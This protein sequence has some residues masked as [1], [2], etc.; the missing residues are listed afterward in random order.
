M[1]DPTPIVLLYE[2]KKEL[3][4][5]KLLAWCILMVLFVMFVFYIKDY[6]KQKNTCQI[7]KDYISYR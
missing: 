7:D 2:E 5:T 3:T 6:L 4:I 1:A